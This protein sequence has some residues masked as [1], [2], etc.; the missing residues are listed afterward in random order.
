MI[1]QPNTFITWPVGED[2]CDAGVAERTMELEP[3]ARRPE[4]RCV[5]FDFSRGRWLSPVKWGHSIYWTGL[6]S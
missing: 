6:L 1:T 5:L 3:E 4:V 2:V